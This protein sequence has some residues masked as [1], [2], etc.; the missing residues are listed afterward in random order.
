MDKKKAGATKSPA[1]AAD[2]GKPAAAEAQPQATRCDEGGQ[3][4]VLGMI[5]LHQ[6]ERVDLSL[7]LCLSAFSVRVFLDD[8]V[9]LADDNV[10]DGAQVTLPPLAPGIHSLTWTFIA[11]VKPW[12]ARSEVLVSGLTRFR[13]RKA[14]PDSTMASNNLAL[15]LEV[16]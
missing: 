5:S 3:E 12:K 16:V 1:K 4:I 6:E 13:M 7:T 10:Q 8:A 14:D 9:L 2:A 11:D 15:L